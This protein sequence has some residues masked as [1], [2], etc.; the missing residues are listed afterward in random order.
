MPLPDAPVSTLTKRAR[1]RQEPAPGRKPQLGYDPRPRGQRY[2]PAV[3]ASRRFKR[4]RQR[5]RGKWALL[6]RQAQQLRERLQSAPYGLAHARQRAFEAMRRA[7]DH[8]AGFCNPAYRLQC[9]RE[10]VAQL[11][12]E[13]LALAEAIATAQAAGLTPPAHLR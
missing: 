12:A 9:Q 4:M 1:R 11:R 10:V 2:A 6:T 8:R 3:Q 5:Q 7:Q 13:R